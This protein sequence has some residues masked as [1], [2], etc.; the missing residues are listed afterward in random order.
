MY[1][2]PSTLPSGEGPGPRQPGSDDYHPIVLSGIKA[3]DFLQFLRLLYPEFVAASL[4][5]A[6]LLADIC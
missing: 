6:L 3:D 5:F 4:I 2:L 1:T